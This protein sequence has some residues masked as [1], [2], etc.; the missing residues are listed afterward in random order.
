MASLVSSCCMSV[1]EY[2]FRHTALSTA[3]LDGLI[4]EKN[5]LYEENTDIPFTLGV[6]AAD[7]HSEIPSDSLFFETNWITN[8][9]TSDKPG[10]HWQCVLYKQNIV[11]NTNH[12][13]PCKDVKYYII[14]SWGM[15][16]VEVSQRCDKNDH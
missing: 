1:P 11:N 12:A 13:E 10:T 15:K 8:T 14:N 16:H 3:N 4:E 5:R 6:Y 9:D 7:I 2:V